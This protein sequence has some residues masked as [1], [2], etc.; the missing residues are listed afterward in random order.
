MR[1]S[2][3]HAN[4]DHI[5]IVFDKESDDVIT[6]TLRHVRDCPQWG[7]PLCRN[8]LFG[9]CSSTSIL[10]DMLLQRNYKGHMSAVMNQ[11]PKEL[12]WNGGPF[13]SDHPITIIDVGCHIGTY[14]LPLAKIGY[15][16][17]SI[18]GSSHNINCLEE[19]KKRNNLKGD[20]ITH[21]RVLSNS[22]HSC[23]FNVKSSPY[24][25]MNQQSYHEA[26]TTS[27]LD[28]I[29][30]IDFCDFIKIDVEGYEREVLEGSVETINKFKP[31]IMMEINNTLLHKRKILPNEIFDKLSKLGYII[32]MYEWNLEDRQ[33]PS[34]IFTKVDVDEIFPLGLE[35]IVCFHKDNDPDNVIEEIRKPIPADILYNQLIYNYEHTTGNDTIKDYFN[36]LITK[37]KVVAESRIATKNLHSGVEQLSPSQVANRPNKPYVY[38][39]CK[40]TN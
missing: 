9:I 29:L 28:S 7:C 17:I 22:E 12:G 13:L 11:R 36:S 23:T 27:T 16:M 34:I 5:D 30:N 14:S 37:L 3:E 18:D 2:Y 10:T 1:L 26:D 33:H 4:I 8:S 31:I 38:K 20:I 19:S 35:D 21:R 24:S 32:A 15:N 39:L 40:S 6:N 25:F